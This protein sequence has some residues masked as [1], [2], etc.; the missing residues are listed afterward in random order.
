MIKYSLNLNF[1]NKISH[2]LEIYKIL[3]ILAIFYREYNGMNFEIYWIFSVQYYYNLLRFTWEKSRESHIKTAWFCITY[4]LAILSK[5]S[6]SFLKEISERIVPGRR[7]FINHVSSI[8]EKIPLLTFSTFSKSCK[9]KSII[10]FLF[11]LF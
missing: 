3:Q 5:F 2:S 6:D 7:L 11:I 1:L 9:I 4:L 8:L 10:C